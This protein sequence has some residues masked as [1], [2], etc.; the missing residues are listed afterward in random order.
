MIGWRIFAPLLTAF[1]ALPIFVFAYLAPTPTDSLYIFGY[2]YV[3]LVI[4]FIAG[5]DWIISIEE[6]KISF[7]IWSILLAILP[8]GI[9]AEFVYLHY[10]SIFLWSQ[11]LLLIWLSML[12]D[13]RFF[14]K[15]G[16]PYYLLFRITGTLVLSLAILVCLTQL[17]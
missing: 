10:G 4:A 14:K 9:I 15:I 7:L 2:I 13:W 1:G 8:I 17:T 3:S 5:I 12:I 16:V 6:Q 11:Y